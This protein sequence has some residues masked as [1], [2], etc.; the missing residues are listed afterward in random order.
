MTV[1][2]ERLQQ[3]YDVTRERSAGSKRWRTCRKLHRLTV[4]DAVGYDVIR[5]AAG[6]GGSCDHQFGAAAA[7]VNGE[8]HR[9]AIRATA[10]RTRWRSRSA[11]NPP[12]RSFR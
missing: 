11:Y 12:A 7:A 4:I 8:L 1:L 6:D 3:A 10:Q 9:G 2:G 5:A